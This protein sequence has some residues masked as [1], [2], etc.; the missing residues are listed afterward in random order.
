MTKILVF[1]TETSGLPPEMS[2]KNWE[3]RKIQQF[4]NEDKKQYWE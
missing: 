3:E 2:G 1:D 4:M